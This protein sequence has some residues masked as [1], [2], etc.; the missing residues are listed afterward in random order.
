MRQDTRPSSAKCACA[1]QG[2]STLQRLNS[3]CSWGQ[4]VPPCVRLLERGLCT[5]ISCCW[6]AKSSGQ[7]AMLTPKTI[8][9]M[10]SQH[11]HAMQRCRS[12]WGAASL[13]PCA[14][15][16]PA[17]G[18]M[19]LP[20]AQNCMQMGGSTCRQL[21]KQVGCVSTQVR[22][23]CL[24]ESLGNA[25][26][27]PYP[28]SQGTRRSGLPCR[29]GGSGTASLPICAPHTPPSQP[30]W[31]RGWPTRRRRSAGQLPPPAQMHKQAMGVAAVRR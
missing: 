1:R 5:S 19:A 28:T 30:R 18:I 27:L 16:L 20:P 7:T 23:R 17:P 3:A 15:A 6:R 2:C 13:Q 12:L 24:T 9:S 22:S 21:H 4:L 26:A 29:Q 31:P 11:R 10:C 25:I 14:G 8:N